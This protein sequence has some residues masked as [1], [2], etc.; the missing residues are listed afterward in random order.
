MKIQITTDSTCD[1]S[2]D[3]LDKYSIACLPLAVITDDEYLDKVTITPNQIFEYVE[4]TKKLPKTA[5]R[6]VEDFKEFF[7]QF[8]DNGQV[9]IHIGIGSQ[10][11][12][13]FANA[14]AAADSF[15]NKVFVVDSNSLST[16][17]GL[18]VVFAAEL[19][20]NG[21]SANYICES[22]KERSHF[23]Q[24]GFVVD[25]LEYLYRGGRCSAI[26]MFGANL[27]K[28][29]PRLQ[30]VDGKII[31]SGKYRGKIDLVLK[32]YIDDVLL[33]YNKPDTKRCFVTHASADPSLVKEII[34]YV[35]EKHIFNEVLETT[36]GATI[37]SHCGQGTLGILYIN[38][39]DK[40]WK[41]LFLF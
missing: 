12:S 40:R 1:L 26:A 33:E 22:I 18:L 17:T 15:D 6:S 38:D 19:A 16:G 28:L 24:A 7:S 41:I 37:T 20:K 13:C 34:N 9:V 3:I 21:K 10:L 29:K 4:K 11:S 14:S 35:K 36:A 39:G 30:V 2:K 32:K 23:V 8:V 25:T 31:V 27:L 5:A